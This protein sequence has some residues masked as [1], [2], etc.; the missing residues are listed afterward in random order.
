MTE[1]NQAFAV[2]SATSPKHANGKI[3]LM[4]KFACF[5]SPVPFTASPDDPEEH[6]RLIYAAAMKG[7]YG[8]IA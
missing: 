3:D 6:G 1:T 8:P 2:E 4:V 5:P 7:D